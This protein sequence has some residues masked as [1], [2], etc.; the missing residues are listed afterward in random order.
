MP[1]SKRKGYRAPALEK[2]LDV[3][4][5]LAEASAPM[6][7]AAIA[8]A[9]S[10]SRSEIFRMLSVL[11]DRAFIERSPSDEGFALTPRLLELA[12]KNPPTHSLLQAALPVMERLAESARQSCHLAVQSGADMVVI[13]RVESSDEVGLAVRIGHRRSLVESTSGRVL[14]AFQ[15]ETR[16]AE[17]LRT[18]RGR[19]ACD[20]A[21]LARDLARIRRSGHRRARSSFVRGIVDLGAPVFDGRSPGAVAALTVPCV[22]KRIR[23]EPISAAAERVEAAAREISAVLARTAGG[24]ARLWA[25]S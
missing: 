16:R 23:P 2:G 8:G 3:L 21:E 4:E 9:L 25:V 15:P 1:R 7:T 20:E 6:T 24:S 17:W 10:R 14:L 18:L 13:A 5:L 11:E 19:V 12:M 22:Q